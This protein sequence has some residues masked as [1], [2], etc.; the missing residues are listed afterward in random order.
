MANGC[1]RTDPLTLDNQ[2]CFSVYSTAHDFT[3][4]CRTLLDPLG[5]TC[6][7][8]LVLLALLQEDG[9][10]VKTLGARNPSA[11]AL[12]SRRPQGSTRTS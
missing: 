9:V 1:D 2:L 5:L 7:Q 8:Y 12:R 4:L 11:Y 3:R 10:S 6:T